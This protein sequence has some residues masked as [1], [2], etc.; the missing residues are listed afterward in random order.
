MHACSR[1][2]STS[3]NIDSKTIGSANDYLLRD[4]SVPLLGPQLLLTPLTASFHFHLE[5]CNFVSVIKY[6]CVQ[7]GPRK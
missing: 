6:S 1:V 5:V 4:I 3:L 7:K 2:P